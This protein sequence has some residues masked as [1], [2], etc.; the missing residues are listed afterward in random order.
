MNY[1]LQRK[2]LTFKEVQSTQKIARN[3]LRQGKA[4]HG[5]IIQAASQTGGI[6][7]KD[8]V[9]HSP[10]GGLWL[11]VILLKKIPLAY[12]SGFSIR[13][14]LTII[15]ELEKV[16]PLAFKL[17]WPN[18]LVLATKKVGGILTELHSKENCLEH[19]ILGIGINVNNDPSTLPPEISNQAISIKTQLDNREIPLIEIRKAVLDAIDL[20]LKDFQKE[21]IRSLA[22]LWNHRSLTFNR[23]VIFLFN[24]KKLRGIEKGVTPTGELKLLIDDKTKTFS[25]GRILSYY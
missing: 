9:W 12:F 19:L 3:F 2:I 10:F 23:P 6:G 14:G 5:L 4:V 24:D 16:L 1:R 25:T 11:S 20:V 15:D 13:I 22:S 17:K 21:P 18:D 8:R 7:Q